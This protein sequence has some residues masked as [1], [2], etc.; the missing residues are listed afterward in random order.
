MFLIIKIVAG[1]AFLLFTL[2]S[3]S[4]FHLAYYRHDLKVQLKSFFCL[5][6]S[7]LCLVSLFGAGESSLNEV[8]LVALV[9]A[10]SLMAITPGFEVFVHF[11]K[12]KRF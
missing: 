1:F 5:V 4:S 2:L 3:Y 10:A 9:I 8:G 7:L 6:L 12:A 11:V